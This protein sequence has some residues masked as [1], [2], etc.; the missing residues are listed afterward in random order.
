MIQKI[1]FLLSNLIV[2]N[3]WAESFD[4]KKYDKRPDIAV[5]ILE[6]NPKFWQ[7]D[8]KIAYHYAKFLHQVG[9]FEQ[10]NRLLLDLLPK[11]THK[12]YR[13]NQMFLL[14]QNYD[15]LREKE[16]ARDYFDNIEK[17]TYYHLYAYAKFEEYEGNFEKALKLYEETLAKRKEAYILKAY[18]RTLEKALLTFKKEDKTLYEKYLHI[19][20][21]LEEFSPLKLQVIKNSIVI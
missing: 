4:P 8:D 16:L 14:A 15:A 3:I 5:Q 21:N 18:V 17:K 19:A 9:E 12:S 13:K 10:S 6:K 1:L 11:T 20:E 2:L 7:K